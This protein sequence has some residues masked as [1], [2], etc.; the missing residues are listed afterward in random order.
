MLIGHD[1]WM[2]LLVSTDGEWYSETISALRTNEDMHTFLETNNCAAN[3]KK[4]SSSEALPYVKGM[5]KL[6][7]LE[8]LNSFIF[9]ISK[10]LFALCY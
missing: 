2:H 6:S 4:Q 10:K 8:T 7:S 3:L 5:W 1:D 9:F